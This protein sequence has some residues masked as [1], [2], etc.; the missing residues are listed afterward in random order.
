[1]REA[2]IS[3]SSDEARLNND[4]YSNNSELCFKTRAM[5]EDY[6]KAFAEYLYKYLA[7]SGIEKPRILEVGANNIRFESGIYK[8]IMELDARNRTD[9]AEAATYTIMD[10]SKA[11]ITEAKE[12]LTSTETF[13]TLLRIGDVTKGIYGNYDVIIANEL[14]DDLGHEVVAKIGG[15]A[16]FVN[17]AV[18]VSYTS[19]PLF[20]P[21]WPVVIE[22]SGHGEVD[23]ATYAR[24]GDLIGMMENGRVWSFS[25]NVDRAISN[26]AEALN[27]G[28]MLWMHDY[29]LLYPAPKA[30]SNGIRRLFAPSVESAML[31]IENGDH[32]GYQVTTDVNFM[33]VAMSVSASGMSIA[34]MEDHELFVGRKDGRL[35]ISSI[36]IA[37][38]LDNMPDWK[39]ELIESMLGI[40]DIGGP[41]LSIVSFLNSRFSNALLLSEGRILPRSES[42]LDLSKLGSAA[43]NLYNEIS[44]SF[45]SKGIKR[46]VNASPLVDIAAIKEGNADLTELLRA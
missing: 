22:V 29:G 5:G 8:R 10:I 23:D 45:Y 3:S 9:F 18:R 34:K 25:E 33:Q 20:E 26:M 17:Y 39:L 31:S 14:F 13:K 15:K 44:A 27:S 12:S 36:A 2:T 43:E 11:A 30:Y 41:R 7:I 6:Q 42:I 40:R 4:F 24:Y 19:D 28:G 46:T 21:L 1:M 16:Y 38:A 32:L 35:N 37:A